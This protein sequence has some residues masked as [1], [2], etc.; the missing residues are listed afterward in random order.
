MYYPDELVEEVRDK[1]DIVDVVGSYV[2]LTK[3]GN[4]YFGRCT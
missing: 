2:H 4:T 3:R 1:N